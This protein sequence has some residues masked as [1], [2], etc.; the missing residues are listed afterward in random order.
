MGFGKTCHFFSLKPL[1]W[2]VGICQM[3]LWL[4]GVLRDLF[5]PQNIWSAEIMYR[6]NGFLSLKINILSIQSVLFSWHAILLEHQKFS[7]IFFMKNTIKAVRKVNN[8]DQTI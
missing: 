1:F 2:I 8:T 7:W 6:H 5:D 4:I 3:V